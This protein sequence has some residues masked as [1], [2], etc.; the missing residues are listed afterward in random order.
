MLT[1]GGPGALV[2]EENLF[3]YFRARVKTAVDHQ[4]APVS[5][6]AVFYLSGVLAD[7]GHREE[8]AEPAPTTLVELRERA[9]CAPLGEAVPLWKRLGDQ[10]LV[11]VGFFREN[12]S[13]RKV[14]AS[15]YAE[16][17]RSAYA[18]LARALKDP[19]SAVHDIFGEL[20]ERYEACAEVIKE[21]RDESRECNATDI[22]KL[23]EEYLMTGS[24]RIAERLRQL[25][26]VPVRVGGAG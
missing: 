20:A 24:P 17:G 8:E 3:D 12:L 11:A 9:S 1:V 18:V 16:M 13:H 25:G 22:V 4:R 15:Y 5:E 21:V 26:V 19:N 2:A 6:S 14:S 10:S 7:Q 23:Y